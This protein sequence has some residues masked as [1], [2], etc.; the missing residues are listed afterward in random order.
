MAA[1]PYP[2]AQ[3]VQHKAFAYWLQSHLKVLQCWVSDGNGAPGWEAY[4]TGLSEMRQWQLSPTTARLEKKHG[5]PRSK[6]IL[7]LFPLSLT[8]H[9]NLS[10]SQGCLP[11]SLITYKAKIRSGRHISLRYLIS[12]VS[13]FQ[14]KE[15]GIVR[16][17]QLLLQEFS[18]P[19]DFFIQDHLNF[20]C[21]WQLMFILLYHTDAEECWPHDILRCHDMSNK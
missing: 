1:F 2:A 4:L 21:I 7:S 17:N 8:I 3:P 18:A 20:E 6:N 10:C 12:A 16:G 11:H 15:P 5:Q 14:L 19:A 9:D 13:S